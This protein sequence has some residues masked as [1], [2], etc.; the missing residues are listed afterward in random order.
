MDGDEVRNTRFLGKGF[1]YGYGYAVSQVDDLLRR[2][3]AELERRPA[4]PLIENTTFRNRTWNN[5]YDIDA[6]NWFLDQFLLHPGHVE[7]DGMG[8]DP[9]RDLAVVNQF[10]RGGVSDP[11][12]DRKSFAEEC[13]NAWREFGQ[14]PGMR[15]RWGEVG[16]VRGELRTAEQQT[17][18]SLD[19]RSLTFSTGGRSFT[20]KKTGIAKS[21]SPAIAEIAARNIR[22]YAG[23]FSNGRLGLIGQFESAAGKTGSGRPMELVDE[24]GVPILYARG[25]NYG[26]RACAGVSF[27]DQ[28]WLRFLVRGIDLTNA[29]MTAVDQ[30]GNQ[31]ARY[32]IDDSGLEITVHPNQKLTDELILAIAISAPELGGYFQ[33]G[34]GG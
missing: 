1:G 17:I 27:P 18:A 15:L 14:Q 28:R 11:A 21:W 31:V 16:K 25:E 19:R 33:S 3:A 23:H 12:G 22:D 29:I 4:G 30:E 32:R 26:F 20:L 6:V 24:T 7:P 5:G 2:V 13:A 34:G 8:E 10:T 9:W